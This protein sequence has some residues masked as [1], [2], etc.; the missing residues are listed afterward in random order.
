MDYGRDMQSYI[1]MEIQSTQLALVTTKQIGFLLKL[2]G[3]FLPTLVACFLI[4]VTGCPNEDIR[5]KATK[6]LKLPL[7][8]C[9]KKD[10]NTY[11]GTTWQI[12]FELDHADQSGTY[13]L[14][15]ALATANVAE[16]QVCNIKVGA[17]FVCRFILY[18]KERI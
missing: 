16:L 10:N 5:L 2:Q 8:Y 7:Y 13:K 4:L 9:R 17:Q 15:L 11:E 14:R 6:F 18:D 3:S 1:L 12:K